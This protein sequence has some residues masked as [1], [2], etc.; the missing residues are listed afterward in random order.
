MKLVVAFVVV[1]GMCAVAG[2]GCG[3][4]PAITC[5]TANCSSNSKTYQAC[6]NVDGSV[7]YNF[8]GMSCHAAS[9]N[10]GASQQC[11]MQ[12]ADYCGG[13][14]TGG[15]GG[16]GGGGAGGGGGG[17]GNGFCSTTFSGAFSGT[18]SPCAVTITYAASADVTTVATAGN[19]I[20]GTPYTWTG[21][22]FVLA[23]MP[24][25]GTFDQ[26]AATGASDQVTQQGSQNPPLWEAGGGQGTTIGS[27]TLSITSLGPST[28]INGSGDLLYSSPHGT[29]TGTLADQNPMTAMPDVMQTVTF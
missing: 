16:T 14:G 5:S 9:S 4:S 25:T 24:A 13:G 10:Q 7:T 22:S 23:G 8:G 29:W 11:A 26:S 12:V 2:W 18:Y 3:G 1:T 17:G 21:F 27:A 6:A 19:L 15:T 20:P 28:A